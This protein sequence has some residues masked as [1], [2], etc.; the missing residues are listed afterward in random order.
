MEKSLEELRA[1]IEEDQVEVDPNEAGTQ[2]TVESEEGASTEEVT[3]EVVVEEDPPT[4]TTE[5]E[6]WVVPGRFKTQA[7]VLKAYQELESFTGRQSSEIQKLRT[8]IVVPQ[9]RGE[10]SDERATRLKRFAEELAADP[11]AALDARTR[12]IVNELKG[13][14]KASEFKRV[15]DARIADTN[16]DF[17]ELDPTMAAIATQYSD[18]IPDSMRMDPR[19][20]DILHLAA[21]GVK[22]A[23]IVKK[24]EAKGAEKGEKVHR[25]KGKARVEGPSN[26]SGG[27][28]LDITKL[29]AAEMKAA[30]EKGDIDI[31][32]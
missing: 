14:V 4:V 9:E 13:D 12:K 29:S 26:K 8:A 16:S 7:D 31:N 11:E 27:K 10:S 19:L 21:R 22:A 25:Q 32:E 5:E 20:L 6:E 1:A 24:A 23:E 17:A 2:V 30:F 3:P 15:Y 28:K 18:L